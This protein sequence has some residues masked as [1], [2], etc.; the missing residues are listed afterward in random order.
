MKSK[1]I[2]F[3][4]IILLLSLMFI[5]SGGALAESVDEDNYLGPQSKQAGGEKKVLMVVVRFPDATPTTPLEKIRRRVVVGLDAYVKEQSYGL[6]SIKA[7]FRGYIMLPSPLDDYKISPYNF[8]VDK[9]RLRKL[10]EDTMTAIEKDTDFSVY[11]HMLIVPAVHTMPGKGYG[12]ICYCANPGML[13]GV[14]RGYTPRYLTL[15]AA[16]G[17]EFK[18]GVFVGTENAHLGM[19]AH[20]YFHALAGMK[21]GKRLAPCLYDYDRQSDA[22]AGLPSFEHHAIYMGPW[23]IMSQHFV[24]RGQPPPGLSSF[25]KIRL[26][27]IE[28]HQVRIVKPGETAIAFLSPLS[29]GGDLLAVKIPLADGTYYLVENRQPIG[30]DSILPDSGVLILK[31][32]PEAAEGYGTVEVKSAG[33]SRDFANA[34]HKLEMNNRSIFIDNSLS[35]FFQRN[36]IAIIPLWKEKDTL[37][38]LITTPDHSEAAIKAARAIQTLLDLNLRTSDSENKTAILEAV[39]AFKNKDFEKCHAIATKRREGR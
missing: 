39:S 11:D 19:F 20:D 38:V 37:G 24:R 8:R 7:D 17:K 3:R 28:K 35:G 1:L 16:G 33:G 31:V 22:S 34:A 15:K 30:F 6:A 4:Q 27:W 5:I 18:G 36:N 32:H 10:I 23:D 13:S 12:M 2:I 9:S 25:T 29:K 21:D 14:T 26:G